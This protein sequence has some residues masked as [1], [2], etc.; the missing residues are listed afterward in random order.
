MD[1]IHLYLN[2][3]YIVIALYLFYGIILS[4]LV[5]IVGVLLSPFNLLSVFWL[6]RNTRSFLKTINK[7]SLNDAIETDIFLHYNL[8]SLWSVILGKRGYEYGIYLETLS[9]AMGKKAKERTLSIFG[10]IVFVVVVVD[11]TTWFKGGHFNDSI[12]DEAIKIKEIN[13]RN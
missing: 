13:K 10:W 12:D 11:F 7:Y 1:K 5:K 9:S 6:E 4:T 3:V 8:R 2:I